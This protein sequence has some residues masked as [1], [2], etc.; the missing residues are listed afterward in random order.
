MKKK[1]FK[2]TEERDPDTHQNVTDPQHCFIPNCRTAVFRTISK[3]GSPRTPQGNG[4][5]E[6]AGGLLRRAWFEPQHPRHVPGGPRSIL[7]VQPPA[8]DAQGRTL[9]GGLL[10]GEESVH[11]IKICYE[12]CFYVVLWI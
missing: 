12:E 2:V 7:Q 11:G 1:I 10:Q 5:L 4:S 6:T 9:P 3:H 8:G